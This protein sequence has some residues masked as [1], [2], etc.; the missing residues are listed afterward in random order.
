MSFGVTS[1][2]PGKVG[3]F[4]SADRSGP[5]TAYVGSSPMHN[6]T[7]RGPDSTG[8]QNSSTAAECLEGTKK[9]KK[10]TQKAAAM[11]H[12]ATAKLRACSH[13]WRGRGGTVPTCA[14]AAATGRPTG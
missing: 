3:L 11:I 14:A 7:G 6:R 4:F 12:P 1:I 5:D 9:P 2:E 13:R 10:R 8:A